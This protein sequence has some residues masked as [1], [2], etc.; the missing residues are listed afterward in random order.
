MME[1]AILSC[2]KVRIGISNCWYVI[3][4]KYVCNFVYSLNICLLCGG[5][6]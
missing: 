2:V 6:V 1:L 5:I 4:K 3:L